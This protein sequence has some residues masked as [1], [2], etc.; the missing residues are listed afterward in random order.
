MDNTQKANEYYNGY[1]IFY[2]FALDNSVRTQFV[3]NREDVNDEVE[4][5]K[6]LGAYLICVIQTAEA[7][8]FS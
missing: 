1:V 3:E 2:G 8:L 6:G 5:L 7:I 4:K